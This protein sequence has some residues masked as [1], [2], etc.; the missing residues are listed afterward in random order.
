MSITGYQGISQSGTNWF[1]TDRTLS[2]YDQFSYTRGK[3]AFMAGLSIRKFTIGRAATN[4]GRG[5]F[6]FDQT[7][8]GG[9]R[10]PAFIAGLPTGLT[11]P[12]TQVKGSAAQWRDGFFVQDTWQVSQKLTLQYGLRYELPQVA[13]SLNGVGRIMTPDLTALFPAAGGTTPANAVAYP[14]FHFTP[15]QHKDIG[16]RLGFSYR[17]TEKTVLR[18]GGGIY[19]NANQMN[20]YTLSTNTYPY[21]ANVTNSNSRIN[22]SPSHSTTPTSRPQLR[23]DWPAAPI[24]PLQ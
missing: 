2:G 18:G 4:T 5:Q 15:P 13:Y 11:S 16:P 9:R 1:Q 22:C 19:Y 20:S 6:T 17:V 3:H 21:T 23:L 7:L 10:A 24:A 8:A 12:L 14:G